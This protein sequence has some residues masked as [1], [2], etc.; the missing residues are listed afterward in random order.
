M[1]PAGSARHARGFDGGHS[2]F[3]TRGRGA[4]ARVPLRQLFAPLVALL[5]VLATAGCVRSSAAQAHGAAPEFVGIEGWLN[6]P[7][8]SMERLRGQVVLVQFWTHRCGSCRHVLP[9][10]QLWHER[11]APEGLVVVGIHT[12]ETEAEADVA[13]LQ[14]AIHELGLTFPVAL[15]SRYETWDAYGNQYWPAHY[16]VDRDGDIVLKHVGEGDYAETEAEIVALL[17]D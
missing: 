4:L 7:P 11:Y 12:P 9:S 1:A 2:K 16:L 14:A 3:D 6:T 8:Q 15:D 13:G 17:D 10:T 5:A